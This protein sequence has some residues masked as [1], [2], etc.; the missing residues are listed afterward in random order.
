M[1][2]FHVNENGDAGPCGA[3][4]GKCPFGG[5]DEHYSSAEAAREAYEKR[6]S[7][8]AE[9]FSRVDKLV[10]DYGKNSNVFKSWGEIHRDFK[11]STDGKRSVLANLKGATVLAP[12]VG[13]KPLARYNE[14]NRKIEIMEKQQELAA[15]PPSSF[16][17]Y[18]PSFNS[19]DLKKVSAGERYYDEFGSA[20]I[21]EEVNAERDFVK[22][23]PLDDNGE[24]LGR[25]M[26]SVPVAEGRNSPDNFFKLIKLEL[27]E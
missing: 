2:K 8:E 11:T 18:S 4:R 21:V 15:N 24:P 17:G 10:Q 12:W 23:N 16:A 20:Y 26:G 5:E 9:E 27:G 1:A 7:G 13:P 25:G 19:M 6:Q 14:M 3:K 22:M